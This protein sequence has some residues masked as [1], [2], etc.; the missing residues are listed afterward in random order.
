MR[1]S[2]TSTAVDDLLGQRISGLVDLLGDLLVH[3][4]RAL[5]VG[6]PALSSDAGAAAGGEP[7]R[8]PR[9]VTRGCRLATPPHEVRTAGR[10]SE[11]EPTEQD[12]AAT[13]A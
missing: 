1:G 12:L 9:Q 11:R 6:M 4:V 10:R 3:D 7:T 8:L 13:S 2:A 5:R